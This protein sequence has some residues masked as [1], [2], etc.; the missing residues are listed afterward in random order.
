MSKKTCID[1]GANTASIVI[2][3]LD[4]KGKS[5]N[6]IYITLGTGVGRGL[7]FQ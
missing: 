5:Y 2:F 6:L 7:I 1:N 4:T 3:W